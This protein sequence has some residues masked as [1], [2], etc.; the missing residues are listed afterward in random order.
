METCLSATLTL[1]T[2]SHLCHRLFWCMLAPDITSHFLDGG[3]F[4]HASTPSEVDQSKD[5]STMGHSNLERIQN[6]SSFRWPIP[7]YHMPLAVVTQFYAS[8]VKSSDLLSGRT[9]IRGTL[10]VFLSPLMPFGH[11]S[12][13]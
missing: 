6:N 9:F 13:A 2:K 10:H 5:N 4:Q 8:G 7:I 1:H 11:G 3:G 12:V